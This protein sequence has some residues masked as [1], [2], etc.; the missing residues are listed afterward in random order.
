MPG[1]T[2]RHQVIQYTRQSPPQT[3]SCRLKTRLYVINSRTNIIANIANAT[4][5]ALQCGLLLD[6]SRLDLQRDLSV[7]L[8]VCHT[9]EPNHTKNGSCR[10][11][12][13]ELA[14]CA[15]DS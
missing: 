12:E 5:T 15:A 7:C 14:A 6:V 4:R 10:R 9:A 8:S 13:I 3:N 2:P 1:K 11:S